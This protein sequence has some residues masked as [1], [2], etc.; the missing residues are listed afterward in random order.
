[1]STIE[2][3][4]S[5]TAPAEGVDP[6]VVARIHEERRT[7]AIHAAAQEVIGYCTD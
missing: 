6:E 3:T 5:D 7:N 2:I 4:Q 1:M